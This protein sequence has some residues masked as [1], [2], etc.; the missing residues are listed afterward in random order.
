[1][2]VDMALADLQRGINLAA[3]E[4]EKSRRTNQ[5]V[6]RILDAAEAVS[7]GRSKDGVSVD[8]DSPGDADVR[9][10]VLEGRPDART[11]LHYGQAFQTWTQLGDGTPTVYVQ[12]ISCTLLWTGIVLCHELDHALEYRDGA[13]VPGEDLAAME[14]GGGTGVSPR[15]PI[16]G[17]DYA[18]KVSSRCWGLDPK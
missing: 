8:I 16:A 5:R 11:G 9:V 6:E 14:S 17:W 15:R 2:N 10:V 4:W 3:S 7:W 12:P 13:S 18:G 1:M